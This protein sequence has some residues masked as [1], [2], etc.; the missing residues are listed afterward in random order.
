VQ[1]EWRGRGGR[2]R[3]R[4]MPQAQEQEQEQE[5]KQKQKQE[6]EQAQAHRL[7][8]MG[9]RSAAESE[10]WGSARHGNAIVRQCHGPRPTIRPRFLENA[11]RHEEG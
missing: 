4:G 11:P 6:Q 8:A 9:S 1:A 2:E 3:E 7:A 5:Q 10:A